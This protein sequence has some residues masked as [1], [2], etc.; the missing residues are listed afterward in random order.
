MRSCYIFN[1]CLMVCYPVQITYG[2]IWNHNATTVLIFAVLS[3]I[4]SLSLKKYKLTVPNKNATYWRNT[5]VV[6]NEFDMN[7]HWHR[8]G[9]LI[10]P[11]ALKIQDRTRVRFSS[12]CAIWIFF[13]VF[14]TARRVLISSKFETFFLENLWRLW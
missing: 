9:K 14:K 3:N 5:V 10:M 7:E 12:N 11:V 6:Q 2:I 1:N 8:L 4:I 13:S